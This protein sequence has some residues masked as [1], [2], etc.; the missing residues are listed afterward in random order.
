MKDLD[1]WLKRLLASLDTADRLLADELQ[2][3]LSH[4]SGSRGLDDPGQSVRNIVLRVGRPV[5]A[6]VGGA[7]QLE[8]KDSESAVWRSRLQASSAQL[9]RAAGAVGRINV[10]DRTDVP[11]VGTGWLVEKDAIATNR[12]VAMEFGQKGRGGFTFKSPHGSASG[13]SIDFL[14]EAGRPDE[15]S[16]PIVEILHIE[17][18][19]GP[20]FALLRVGESRGQ[21]LAT[22]I[23]L[24][25]SPPKAMQQVAVMGYPAKD[26]R[27]PDAQLVH[28]IFGDVF[29]KKR[30]A[31]GQLTETKS[32]VLLHDCS[33]LGGNS[34]SV[35][36]DLAT[37]QAVGLHFAGRFLQTNYAVPAAVVA[38]RLEQARHPKSGK[39]SS[40]PPQVPTP[41]PAVVTPTADAGTADSYEVYVEGVP[42]DYIGRTG[43]DPRFIG[44]DVPL[45]VV[46]NAA[47]VLT[48]PWNGGQESELNYQHFSVVMSRSRRLCLFSA[49]NIDGATPRR[50]KRPAWR[51]DARIPVS[52]QIKDECYGNEPKFARGH[53]TRREDP[54]WGEPQDAS[55]GNSDSMH[56]TNTVPQ[57]Q[58]FNAG[59]WLALESYALDHARSDHMRISVMTGPFLLPDDP[60]RDGVLI[61]RSFWKIIAFIHDETRELSATGYTMSQESFL[62]DE[63]FVFGKHQTAQTRISAIE[64][65]A[66]LSFGALTAHDPFDGDQEG[67]GA[68]LTDPAQIKFRRR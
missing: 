63:E 40:R 39:P 13:V 66:G 30:L 37:G 61:P 47:D 8:F 56:V 14:E 32:D 28:S 52:Q 45:P 46:H 59:I 55:L 27:A 60:T 49:G 64:Q 5:L 44:V 41:P 19:D 10:A 4:L 3:H 58:P 31:P 9:Q 50:F 22:P 1:E 51:L 12:H 53:M 21:S 54:V 17:D 38:E 15:L 57:M 23:P 35:V 26:S 18:D 24:S 7:A 36:L 65:R 20:D 42:A 6:I 43:Y 11:Y 34:G 67:V 25:T 68:P 2:R 33:T 29:D 16:F 48:F 62:H